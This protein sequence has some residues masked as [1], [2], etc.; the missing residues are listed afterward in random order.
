MPQTQSL[1]FFNNQGDSLNFKYND[2]YKRYEGDLLFNENG[3]DTFKTIG[4]YTFEYVPSYEYQLPGQLGLDKFQL[5]NETKFNISGCSYSNQS[6]QLIDIPN[7]DPNFYS[8]WIYGTHFES[9][10]PIGSQ[11]K[12]NNPVFEFTNPDQNYTVVETKKDAIMIISN[13]DNSTYDTLYSTVMGLTSS[14]VNV[15]ISGINAIGIYN[16]ADISLNPLLS[17]W[18]EPLFFTK[19]YVGKKL[20]VLNTKK[21]D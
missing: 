20:T 16:Y 4:L 9:K 5:F 18:S 21:N 12:F 7:T 17:Q 15:T 13:V 1:V 10:F 8:K 6:V 2:F 14:Y 11:I 19:Y 3:N